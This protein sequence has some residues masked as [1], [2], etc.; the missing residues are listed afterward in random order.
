MASFYQ[1]WLQSTIDD[2]IK[3]LKLDILSFSSRQM[4]S[5]QDLNKGGRP[6]VITK[7]V[8]QKLE[9]FFSIGATDREACSGAGIALQTLYNYQNKTE[10]FLEQKASWKDR[11]ILKARA[12]VMKALGSDPKLA[13]KYLE[14]RLPGEF[15]TKQDTNNYN[16]ARTIIE[17]VAQQEECVRKQK[18][19]KG[20]VVN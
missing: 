15:G 20:M 12:T 6:T 2:I 16:G 4:A 13:F 11:P 7:E 3:A 8:L 14:R 9:W 1:T 18:E 10:G 5:K 19:E 17:L